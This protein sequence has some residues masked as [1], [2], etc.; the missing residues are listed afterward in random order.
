[1]KQKKKG[2]D[3]QTLHAFFFCFFFIRSNEIMNVQKQKYMMLRH[4]DSRQYTHLNF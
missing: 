4:L 1:M 3:N 2:L